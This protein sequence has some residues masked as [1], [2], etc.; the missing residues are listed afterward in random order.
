MEASQGTFLYL[1]NAMTKAESILQRI[2]QIVIENEPD[3]KVYLYGSRA[4]GKGK[5]DSDWDLLILIPKKHI[6]AED[7]KRIA[8][9]LYD[10]EFESGEV[11]S[12]MI[13]S[14]HDWFTK[15]NVTPFSKSVMTGGK[16]L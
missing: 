10:F 7:E 13:Y 8:W 1:C 3:A 15:F 12:P 4:R 16:L 6:S 11:I 14:E 5:P 9:P 2:K